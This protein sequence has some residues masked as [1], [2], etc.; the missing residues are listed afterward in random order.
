[1]LKRSV[2]ILVT[3]LFAL[4]I[5]FVSIFKSARVGYTF[6]DDVAVKGDTPLVLGE[7]VAAQIEYELPYPGKILPDNSLW[8][9]KAMRDKVW[10]VLTTDDS[11]RAELFLLFADKRLGS[12]KSLFEKGEPELGFSTL[13]KGE[14]YLESAAK[15][16]ESNN[17]K[18]IN[19]AKFARDLSTA[20]LKHNEIINEIRE[21][22]PE[23]AKPKV[24]EV[25]DYAENAYKTA[26]D[27]L[28]SQGVEAPVSPFD[29]D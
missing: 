22:A 2:S 29:W 12:A 27:V 4:L 8:F 5:L 24:T 15:E 17:K 6:N 1:M 21:L 16:L 9:L 26:R 14:K 7:N 28:R 13:S 18:G 19:S 3:F 23:D 20:S 11:R 25:S 10:L